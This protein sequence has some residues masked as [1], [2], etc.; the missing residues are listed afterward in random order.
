MLRSAR[1]DATCTCATLLNRLGIKLCVAVNTDNQNR[2]PSTT[3][4]PWKTC[5]TN[6][7]WV[8]SNLQHNILSSI[9]TGTTIAAS[10][11]PNLSSV[12]MSRSPRRRSYSRSRS[13]SRS[14]RRSRSLSRDRR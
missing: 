8:L 12:V 6:A 7:G 9:V 5:P 3:T 11:L 2:Q 14:P 10:H 1:H 4:I 13:R